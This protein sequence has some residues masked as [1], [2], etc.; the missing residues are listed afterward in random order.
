MIRC[1]ECGSNKALELFTGEWQC[2]NGHIYV[3]G[4]DY[5]RLVK[6]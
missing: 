4:I 1:P 6:Q 5:Q 3:P 2:E